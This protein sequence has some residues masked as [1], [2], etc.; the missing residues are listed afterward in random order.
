MNNNNP[1]QEVSISF[2][3]RQ[4]DFLCGAT[5]G[6]SHCAVFVALVRAM[7]TEPTSFGK[8]GIDVP[9][10]P[11]QAE[12][13]A[14]S[15]SVRYG[16]GRKLMTK[17]LSAMQDVGLIRLVPSK[18][19]SVAS[20]ITVRS[21]TPLVAGTTATGSEGQQPTAAD[22]E[23]NPEINLATAVPTPVVEAGNASD[24]KP[25][26][27]MPTASAPIPIISAIAERPQSVVP[28]PTASPTRSGCGDTLFGQL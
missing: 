27:A 24:G 2:T 18:L 21:W 16:I 13:S 22:P 19:T 12:A 20:M 3:P 4:L 17:L 14:N 1:F 23:T 15:L 9:L 11:C 25:T 10:Q 26:E 5:G 7:A 8:R 28:E 6:V